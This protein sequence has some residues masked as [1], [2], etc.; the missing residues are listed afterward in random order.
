M[1]ATS[2]AVRGGSFVLI[3]PLLFATLAIGYRARVANQRKTLGL[4]ILGVGR[5]HSGY[6][7]D[8]AGQRFRMERSFILVAHGVAFALLFGLFIPYID[9]LT[10]GRRWIVPGAL[11]LLALVDDHQR[12]RRQ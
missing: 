6:C 11:G 4:A 3:W 10:G 5:A 2:I 12:Q 7:D 1:L 8:R 9:F